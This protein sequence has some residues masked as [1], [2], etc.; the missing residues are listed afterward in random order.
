LLI[1]IQV[2]DS[3]GDHWSMFR[4]PNTILNPATFLPG[5]SVAARRRSGSRR[6][7]DI[8]VPDP[9]NQGHHPDYLVPLNRDR[10]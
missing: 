6:L 7:V 1:G 10:A 9:A 8:G 3:A 4:S 5:L 2:L